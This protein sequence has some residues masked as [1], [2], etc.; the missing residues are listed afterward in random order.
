MLNLNNLRVSGND[1]KDYVLPLITSS[2]ASEP[3]ESEHL[4][5]YA[6]A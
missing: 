5:M 6:A 4:S 3:L 1:R 2:R